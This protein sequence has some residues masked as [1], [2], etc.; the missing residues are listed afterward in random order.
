MLLSLLITLT[1]E[2]ITKTL[3]PFN[4]LILSRTDVR[5]QCRCLYALVIKERDPGN[6]LQDMQ[7]RVHALFEEGNYSSGNAIFMKHIVQGSLVKP[8]KLSTLQAWT[9]K[10]V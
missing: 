5:K 4:A 1:V 3:H 2:T 10:F 7:R 9:V 6:R 8:V